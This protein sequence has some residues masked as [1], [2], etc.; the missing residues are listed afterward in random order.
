MAILMQWL[1][2]AAQNASE[3]P[4]LAAMWR[5]VVKQLQSKKQYKWH[6]VRGPM[7]ATIATLLDLGWCPEEWNEW[8]DV[9]GAT[10]RLTDQQ[11]AVVNLRTCDSLL[12][13]LR[14]D[15]QRQLWEQS[16]LQPMLQ[17]R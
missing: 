17:D 11:D 3:M 9:M 16:S 12:R 10:W 5:L 8:I 13:A 15:L 2:I 14:R 7:G 1:Q 4:G 6:S